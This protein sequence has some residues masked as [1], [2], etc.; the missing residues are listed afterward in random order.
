AV[1][2]DAGALAGAGLDQD[3]VAR[4]VQLL[5]ADRRHG[6]ARLVRL[7]LVGHADHV[8]VAVRHRWSP[9]TSRWSAGRLPEVPDGRSFWERGA[10]ESRATGPRGAGRR[11]GPG[12]R[13]VVSRRPGGA[14]RRRAPVTTRAPPHRG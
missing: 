7:D 11:W 13:T 10:R 6:H 14:P 3:A 9:V 2:G 1:V 4:A 12:R 5:D 8:L